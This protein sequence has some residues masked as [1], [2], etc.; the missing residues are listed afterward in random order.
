MRGR[1]EGRKKWMK[2]DKEEGGKKGCVPGDLLV[3]L[4]ASMALNNAMLIEQADASSDDSR[5]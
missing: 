3:A 5:T 1:K 4:A 2:G